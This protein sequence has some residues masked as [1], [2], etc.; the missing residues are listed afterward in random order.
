[1]SSGRRRGERGP[2]KGPRK[3][4]AMDLADGSRPRYPIEDGRYVSE[5]RAVILMKAE[6]RTTQYCSDVTGI[7]VRS[8]NRWLAEGLADEVRRELDI[9][10]EAARN[11]MS[12][13]SVKMAKRLVRLTK[14]AG[15]DDGPKVKACVEGL[16]I[17][18]LSRKHIVVRE[19]PDE[20]DKLTDAELEQRARK[21]ADAE[22]WTKP[23]PAAVVEK[24]L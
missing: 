6:G 7:T 10:L 8:I 20:Y 2:G 9:R 22:G 5:K 24:T 12:A 19:E 21:M 17:A 16:A 23:P 4:S 13:N 1:M 11:I 15:K 18:G 14:K 3:G